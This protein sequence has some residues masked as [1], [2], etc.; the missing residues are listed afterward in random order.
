MVEL[1]AVNLIKVKKPGMMEL[2]II[3]S[4]IDQ[5]SNLIGLEVWRLGIPR[6]NR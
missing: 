6:T 5:K 1:K 2:E 4:E 3:W